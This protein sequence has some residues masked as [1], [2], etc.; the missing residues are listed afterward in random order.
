[1]FLTPT[2]I[3][4]QEVGSAEDIDKI[5]L[6]IEN[7][8]SIA[9]KVY[10]TVS[11]EKED[12]GNHFDSLF[13]HIEY[14]YRKSQIVKVLAWSKYSISRGDIVCYYQNGK[15]LKFSKGEAAEGSGA[16]AQ[17]EFEIY[18]RNDKELKVSWLIPKPKNVIRVDSDIFLK[19]ANANT[20]VLQFY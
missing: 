14:Y 4:G 11:Y 9:K 6:E 2:I 18:Y 8:P 10:D 19:W 16:Y 7:D 17:L 5:I 15:V 1:M 13:R 20:T 3:F 12:G